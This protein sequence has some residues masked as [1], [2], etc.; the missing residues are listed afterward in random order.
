MALS[1]LVGLTLLNLGVVDDQSNFVNISELTG[2]AFGRDSG[3]ENS[4]IF[5]FKTGFI[6]TG[7]GQLNLLGY[8]NYRISGWAHEPTS[9]TLF[10]A[11]AMIL[12]LHTKIIVNNL[13]RISLLAIISTFWFFVLSLGSFLA[14]FILYFLYISSILFIKVFPLKL[15]MSVAVTVMLVILFSLYMLEDLINSSL[16]SSKFNL[17]SH[18]M[19][20]AIKRFT[21]FI[22]GITEG[23]LFA[24]TNVT[25]LLIMFIF[26]VTFI[27]SLLIED[28]F[29]P[30][31]LVVFYILIHAMKGSQDSV[32]INIFPFFW[33]YVLYFSLPNKFTKSVKSLK[34]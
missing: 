30:Y 27:K 1:A 9:A 4:Y 10:I 11:P 13:L 28:S 14:F 5:P 20:A 21:F 8:A 25:I 26:F 17:D 31:A 2:G 3:M 16:I 15:S 18:T 33:F 32:F 6:L 24:F 22:P 12:L 34:N 7:S 29:N 23:Q 19:Q